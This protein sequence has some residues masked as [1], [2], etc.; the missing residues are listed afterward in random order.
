MEN[1]VE[2][3]KRIRP[4]FSLLPDDKKRFADLTITL[5]SEEEFISVARFDRLFFRHTGQNETI[6]VGRQAVSWGNGLAF[7]VFDF[8]NPFSPIA[9][10]KDYKPGDD[11][12]Y[13]QWLFDSGGD[14]EL[15]YVARRNE[16]EDLMA[17]EGTTAI[18]WREGFSELETTVLLAKHYDEELYGL[19]GSYNVME[20]VVRADLLLEHTR[21][22]DDRFSFVVNADRSWVIFGFNVY[23]FI[24]Y[25]RNSHGVGDGDYSTLDSALVER[26]GRGE[27][28]TLGRDILDWGFRWEIVPL[29]DLNAIHIANLHD[30]S[31]LVQARL[32][33]ETYES[34]SFQVG[35]TSPYG[36]RG[37]EF[38]GV[39]FAP[40]IFARPA[41]EVFFRASWF[42]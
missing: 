11:L 9:I 26:V 31:G 35:A 37:S 40:G 12:I 38:G 34:F 4:E 23:A 7:H 25:L 24:E 19:G 18:K 32:V 17:T 36:P 27:R 2:N 33:V 3:N 41:A 10:D 22:G 5:D 1:G 21:F 29:I 6:L 39:P 20:A 8:F 16:D 30:E 42:F 13:S 15:V 14:V 28:F